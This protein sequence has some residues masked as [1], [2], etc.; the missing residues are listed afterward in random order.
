MRSAGA[1]LAVRTWIGTS[2]RSMAAVASAIAASLQVGVGRPSTVTRVSSWC[3]PADAAMPSAC[4]TTGAKSGR[5][6]TNMAHRNSTH[7]SRLASGPAAT[8]AIRCH[9]GCRLNA[10]SASC[11][12]TSAS[13]SSSIFT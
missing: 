8:I 9:T 5:P 13:R 6:T 7:S 10:R 3:S 12:G 2:S 4:P 1:P 11:A